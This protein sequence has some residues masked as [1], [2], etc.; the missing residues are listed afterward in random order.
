[1]YTQM[2]LWVDDEQSSPVVVNFT[3]ACT[4]PARSRHVIPTTSGGQQHSPASL[5]GG[6]SD[7]ADAPAS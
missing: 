6:Q 4:C 2:C 7:R 5:A 1:M 3:G